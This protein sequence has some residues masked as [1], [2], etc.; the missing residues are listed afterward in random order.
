MPARPLAPH[1]RSNKA[2]HHLGKSPVY[3]RL[4]VSLQFRDCGR[5]FG[6]EQMVKAKKKQT[7]VTTVETAIATFA[8]MTGGFIARDEIYHRLEWYFD[9][10]HDPRG[11]HT[12]DPNTPLD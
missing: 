9:H 4:L 2:R 5:S 8:A 10:S 12:I 7:T 11:P 3:G 1:H 6:G